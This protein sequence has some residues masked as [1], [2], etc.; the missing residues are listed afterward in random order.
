MAGDKLSSNP[1][2]DGALKLDGDPQNVS[3]YYRDWADTYDRDT[4]AS[5]YSGPRIA[6]DLLARHVSAR[7]LTLLD[8]GC[9]T[10]QVGVAL[11]P[12]GFERVDGFDLSEP[13]AERARATGAYREVLGDIDMMRARETYADA[14]YD[15]VLSVGVFTLGHVPPEALRVLAAIVR[16]RGWLLV[17]VRTHY[18][19]ESD[20]A[21]V[22]QAETDAGRIEVVE[23]LM[24]A[25]Y[26]HDGNGHYW[27]LRR[28]C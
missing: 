4:A 26:N 13:M 19:D 5:A 24:D 27:L 12:L 1:Q 8:A 9:G 17:S 6:A 18:Y 10:G 25:P 23:A 21:S 3:K 7:Q 14:S 20:F 22:L 15:G 11:Q 16:P 28:I 2:I